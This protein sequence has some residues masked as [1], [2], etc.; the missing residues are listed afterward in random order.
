MNKIQCEMCNDKE[1]IILEGN[2]MDKSTQ[3]CAPCLGCSGHKNLD[4]IQKR[5][6][7]KITRTPQGDFHEETVN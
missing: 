3:M 7:I 1:W 5:R 2:P 4:E 6:N